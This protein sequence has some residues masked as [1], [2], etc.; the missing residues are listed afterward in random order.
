MTLSVNKRNDFTLDFCLRNKLG[1]EEHLRVRN[2]QIGNN[3]KKLSAN[4]KSHNSVIK[5]LTL[6][7][8]SLSLF[9]FDGLFSD[10]K[11]TKYILQQIISSN[12]S[13]DLTQI[14]KSLL[15][16]HRQEI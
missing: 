7:K 6:I 11:L 15:N 9:D 8:R 16:I 13:R 14:V 10:T 4:K 12:H 5:R 1:L 2:N 3:L